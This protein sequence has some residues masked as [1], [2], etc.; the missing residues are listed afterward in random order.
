MC[1]GF[2]GNASY[3]TLDKEREPS[4]SMEKEVIG[5]RVMSS[6]GNTSESGLGSDPT[7]CQS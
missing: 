3:Q 6:T 4:T 7:L 2:P 1:E 5:A